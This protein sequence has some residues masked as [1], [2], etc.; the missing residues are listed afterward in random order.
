MKRVNTVLMRTTV[1][2]L[3]FL[4]MSSAKATLNGHW[5]FEE[6]SG[7]TAYDSSGNGLHG[8]IHNA[9]YVPGKVGSYAL[10]FNGSNSFV[11]ILDSHL[12]DSPTV[13]ISL[14]FKPADG[15]NV[16]AN[17][18][19]KGHG[20]MTTPYHSG[21][22]LQ[23][24]GFTPHINAYYGNGSEFVQNSTGGSYA[25]DSWHYLMANLGADGMTIS[26][27]G[28][29]STVPTAGPIVANDSSLFF[30]R[31]SYF[32]RYYT[33]L[34]DDIHIYDSALDIP[35]GQDDA[36]VPAPGAFVLAGIGMG[37]IRKF[38]KRRMLS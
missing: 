1:L 36:Q 12:L 21:Y 35:S 3:V 31:H 23:Y 22:T 17:I 13:G 19:D 33:G 2:L 10:E 24:E 30:G 28:V 25:D 8:F 32:N 11:E 37:L 29:V 34:I 7:T 38:K 16:H 15:Q 26:I 9:T 14:W 4:T 5:D 6:G 18:L 27:D 20:G